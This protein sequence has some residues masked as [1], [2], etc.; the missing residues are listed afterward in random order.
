MSFISALENLDQQGLVRV[1]G[2]VVAVT[3][4]L[5]EAEGLSL[6]VGAECEIVSRSG[7]K[8]LA[9]VVGF[10]GETT[11]L[12]PGSGI[13]G[14]GPRDSVTHNGEVPSVPVSEGLLGRVIDARGNPIDGLGPI[15]NGVRFPIHNEPVPALKRCLI[16]Q[17]MSTGVRAIDG[18]LT[19]GRGQR[20]GIFSGSGVGKSTLLGMIAKNTDLPI[21]VIALI[22]ERGREVREFL[23]RDLGPKGLQNTVVVV[24]TSDEAAVSRIRAANVAT[25][26]AEWFRNS[27]KD[28]LLMVDSLTRVALAQRE[29]GLSAGEPPTTRGYTPSVFAMLPKLLERTGPGE[30]GSITAFYS[31]LVEGDD[32]NDPVGDAVRGIL[33]GQIWLSRDLASKGW[34]PPID[35]CSSTS[36]TMPAVVTPE[37]L[38]AARGLTE[39]LATY[40]EIEDLIRLGAYKHGQDEKS[41]RAARLKPAIEKFLRQPPE[42]ASGF[43]STRKRL[44]EIISHSAEGESA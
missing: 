23:E 35:P 2:R 31:V 8:T 6:P 15:T 20:L 5:V 44:L 24:A 36:R 1:Q 3:G 4:V 18:V 25:S 22:G 39:S 37:H 38:N 16:D 26:I 17:S 10:S 43:D 9:E 29:V 19:T 21:R 41:D 42:E 30:V 40:A 14:I 32:H 27:G 11:H 28:V 7:V 13:D 12:L 33:D 34:F